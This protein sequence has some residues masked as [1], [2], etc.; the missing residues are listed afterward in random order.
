MAT[1]ADEKEKDKYCLQFASGLKKWKTLYGNDPEVDYEST[2]L[3]LRY[4]DVN[5]Y[6]KNIEDDL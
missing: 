1:S 5:K 6:Y 2:N 3:L 4:P